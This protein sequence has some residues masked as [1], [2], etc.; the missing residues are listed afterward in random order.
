MIVIDTEALAG[1]A[2]IVSAI[3]GLVWAVRRKP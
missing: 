3:A 1:L 2:A